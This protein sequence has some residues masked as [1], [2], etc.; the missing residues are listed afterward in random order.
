[1]PSNVKESAFLAASTNKTVWMRLLLCDAIR[2]GFCSPFIEQ[3]DIQT[4]GETDLDGPLLHEGTDQVDRYGFHQGKTLLGVTDG[5]HLFT[6]FIRWDLNEANTSAYDAEVDVHFQ[7]P[8]GKGG[9]YFFLAH[10]TVFFDV[11]NNTTPYQF[12]VSDMDMLNVQ[13]QRRTTDT[14]PYLFRLISPTRPLPTLSS[15][16][17]QH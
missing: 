9:F 12:R 11:P 5:L 17:N 15:F 10:A 14:L 2:T 8:L 16:K 4:S 6:R 3:G 13:W 7:V 1:V